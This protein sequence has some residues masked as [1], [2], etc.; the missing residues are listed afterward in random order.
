MKN[1]LILTSLMV[2][3]L[4]QTVSA[5]ASDMTKPV[6]N[7][8]ARVKNTSTKKPGDYSV[9]LLNN[10][11]VDF[12]K[13]AIIA[14]SWILTAKHCVTSKLTYVT[15]GKKKA[16]KKIAKKF[17]FKN[18]SDLALLQLEGTPFSPSQSVRLL[19][20]PLLPFYGYM[21]GIKVTHNAK[22]GTPRVY[23]GLKL[24]APNKTKLR[25]LKSAGKA[26]SSGSP[27]LIKT[28][29]GDVAVAITH[30]GGQGAQIANARKW[31]KK[32]IQR[33][34][35]AQSANWLYDIGEILSTQ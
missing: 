4:P 7:S 28:D 24:K 5:E 34:T 25:L 35:P 16:S 12:C 29:S 6:A 31:I 14:P 2:V 23:R 13:G 33:E 26:G 32:T 21:S 19:A 20:E 27:W 10:K 8:H 18:K 17:K 30:G 9:S 11:R 15:N 3:L 22:R 1:F